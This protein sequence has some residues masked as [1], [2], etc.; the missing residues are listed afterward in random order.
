MLI[1]TCF[2]IVLVLLVFQFTVYATYFSIIALIFFL[3]GLYTTMC[4]KPEMETPR[5]NP[6]ETF[7]AE[8]DAQIIIG[9]KFWA[10]GTGSTGR[11]SHHTWFR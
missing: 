5:E 4:R 10:Q 1:L 7:K 9:T 3:S 2:Y 11:L 8:D 6:E